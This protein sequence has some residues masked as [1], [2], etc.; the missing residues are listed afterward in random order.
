MY[1]K[2]YSKQECILPK[3]WFEDSA[4]SLL[5]LMS[6]NNYF[7]NPWGLPVAIVGYCLRPLY[8]FVQHVFQKLFGR[9]SCP[10]TSVKHQSAS[11]FSCEHEKYT[12]SK[13]CCWIWSGEVRQVDHCSFCSFMCE[14]LLTAS[15]QLY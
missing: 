7:F 4:K 8:I 10:L 15:A 5:K 6:R 9:H 12:N 14:S 11:H 2:L 13:Q 1:A 3:M